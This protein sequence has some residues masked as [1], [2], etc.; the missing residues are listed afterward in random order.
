MNLSD[1]QSAHGEA[2]GN[3]ECKC[4]YVFHIFV[5]LSLFHRHGD[6]TPPKAGCFTD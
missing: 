5:M 6:G 1:G 3:C 2:A 4:V